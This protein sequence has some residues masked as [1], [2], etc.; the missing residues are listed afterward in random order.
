M[1]DAPSFDI[2]QP[3]ARRDLARH[4]L[5]LPLAD[6]SLSVDKISRGLDGL[7]AALGP[8]EWM[9]WQF[10]GFR[11]PTGVNGSQLLGAGEAARLGLDLEAL[12]GQENVDRLLAG[13]RN[14]TQFDDSVFE[15]KM[16]RWCLDRD[17][18]SGVRFA[19]RYLVKGHLKS[20]DFELETPVGTMVC[21]CKRLHVFETDLTKRLSRIGK[22]FDTAMKQQ[23]VP[24]DVRIECE[25]V[26]RLPSDLSAIASIACSV[27]MSR[28]IGEFLDSGPFRMARSEV[29][30]SP[31]LRNEKHLWHAAVRIGDT[32]TGITDEFTYLR[33][34]SPRMER[35]LT[36]AS[37]RLMNSAH[38][39]L[40]EHLPGVI[41]VDAPLTFARPAALE[42]L[43]LAEY[44]HCVTIG[45]FGSGVVDLSRRNIDEAVVD[46]IFK[47]QRPKLIDRLLSIGIWRSG[48]RYRGTKQL[49]S[50][51]RP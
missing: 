4:H 21:E 12:A 44:A 10:G 40:P 15:A 2:R 49:L 45:I 14:P 3:G 43:M 34:S 8:T 20:P 29:G 7:V 26:G 18:V 22:A 37:G 28:P 47:D 23:S 39:Q 31:V 25:V 27:A 35:A 1:S 16:A 32:P 50:N 48:L 30:K 6:A 19:P 5:S 36:R 13:F 38:R 9:T 41:F 51:R 24:E 17:A 11:L 33:L 42:R 46:W